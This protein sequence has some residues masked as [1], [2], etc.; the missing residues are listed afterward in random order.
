LLFTNLLLSNTVYRSGL[1][2]VI[3]RYSYIALS[4][5]TS[6]LYAANIYKNHL[7]IISAVIDAAL[8]PHALTD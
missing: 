6:Q 5:K 2:S 4:A 8:N 1:T 3:N 7:E